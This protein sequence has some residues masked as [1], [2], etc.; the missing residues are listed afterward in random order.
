MCGI[1]AAVE[2]NVFDAHPQVFGQ[3]SVHRKLSGVDDGHVEAAFDG[4]VQKHR[5]HGVAHGV[6]APERERHVRQPARGQRMGQGLFDF[7]DGVDEI[8]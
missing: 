2:D 3:F 5:M 4:V 1:V 6:V 8:S 7:A